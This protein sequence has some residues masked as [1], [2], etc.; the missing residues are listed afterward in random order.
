MTI[1]KLTPYTGQVANPDGSQTQ[2][3]FTQNMFDQLSYEAQL[4]TQLDAT[5][6]GMNNAVDEVKANAVSAENSA[7][8]AEAAASSAG[9]QGLWPDTGG[10]A[11]K[12]DTYQTQ[13]SGTPTGQYFTALQNTTVD[14]VGD[15]VNWREVVN[16]V[17]LTNSQGQVFGGSVYKGSNGV[18]VANGDV[19][20]S[21]V[22]HLSVQTSEGI[23]ILRM[24]PS[25]SGVIAS[26]TDDD[27]TVGGF[28]VIFYSDFEDYDGDSSKLIARVDRALGFQSAGSVCLL[29][30]S[31][32][33]KEGA[34][35]LENS[36]ASL[37]QRAIANSL[38]GGY[39]E[40]NEVNFNWSTMGGVALSGQSA[41]TSGPIQRSQIISVGG[42]ITIT[43]PNTTK[44]AFFFDRTP[45]SGSVEVR[46]NGAL[47]DT[48][49]C[50]G[51]AEKNV[52]SPY[53]DIA[54]GGANVQF[55]V[56]DAPVE[57]L[58]MVPI[59]DNDEQPNVLMNMRMAV[60]GW[61]S[62]HFLQS[63]E[64]VVS[65][66]ACGS[67]GGADSIFVLALGTN[68]IYTAARSPKA[69]T[70][71]L[72][73]IGD[74][75]ISFRQSNVIVLTVPPVPDSS[76]F[77]PAIPE[78]THND[79][80]LA[81][82]KLASE[83]GWGVVD[84]SNL[85]LARRS[86][87]SDG[88]H[89]NDRGHSEMAS[90]LSNYLTLKL[91]DPV[92]GQTMEEIN[93]KADT[94][95]FRIASDLTSFTGGVTRELSLTGIGVTS[96]DFITGIYL[97]WKTS[98]VMIPIDH[99]QDLQNNVG[100]QLL[101][102]FTGADYSVAKLFYTSPLSDGSGFASPQGPLSGSIIDDYTDVEVIVE[103]IRSS[104]INGV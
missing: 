7:N 104:K 56:I 75:L 18:Y 86:L 28:D 72:R 96:S 17:T 29:G 25:L 53:V 44:M 88:L 62:S 19:V 24:S 34:T 10:S 101:R 33:V 20:P 64:Q 59:K 50:S 5:I 100:I 27:A 60:S 97:R 41:G 15:D 11:N 57:F 69:Y 68:D 4:A 16:N 42:T 61:N 52:L 66:G 74:T 102:S 1:P 21:G 43:R 14:P 90:V 94:T 76:M 93:E 30:D 35:S 51:V 32:T 77:Q 47:L 12:G 82:Y 91:N 23:A 49:D 9:Y 26:L 87:Y 65:V 36:Y 92:T 48:I 80:R 2:T 3:E 84:Y 58:A 39:G 22:S 73:S 71:N 103:F 54:S 31:I 13:V 99:C 67:I 38:S 81:I 83:K 37:F 6:D 55:K 79:Y 89:P 70:D 85:D 78:Y 63:T 98:G 45:T 40:G 46:Q 8:A 95:L